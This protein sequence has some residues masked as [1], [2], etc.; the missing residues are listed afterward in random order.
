MF[1]LLGIHPGPDI[2]AAAA[3]SLAGIPP[4]AAR[5]TL[6]ELTSASLLTEPSPGRY[7]CHD[8]LRAYAAE[9]AQ[10]TD[11]HTDRR[12]AAGRMLDHYLHTAHSGTMLHNPVWTSFALSPPRPGSA[13]E[14]LTT[15]SQAAGWF[16][17]EHKVLLAAITY[18]A[19]SGFELHAWQLATT[20]GV[21]L[22]ARGYWQDW[23]TTSRAAL[24]AV[25]GPAL[26]PGRHPRTGTLPWPWR[27]SARTGTPSITC[28]R[29]SCS[30]SASVTGWARPARTSPSAS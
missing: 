19:A 20:L 24:A 11:S 23:A 30:T 18:A 14:L 13:P 26:W 21:I 25:Q 1:R 12:E 22:D 15:D 6:Q 9:R 3:A 8:L 10:A 29:H 16:E 27:G 4:A 28:K 7:A 17:A 5:R 2:T